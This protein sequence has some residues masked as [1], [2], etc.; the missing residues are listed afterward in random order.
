MILSDD[1]I[2]DAIANSE[3]VIEPF[4][5]TCLGGNSYD[6]HLSDILLTY[7]SKLDKWYN[8]LPIDPREEDPPMTEHTIG[9]DGFVLLPGVLYLG[10]TVEYTETHVHVPNLDGTSSAGRLGISIHATAGRGDVGFRNHWT[11]EISCIQAVKVYAGMPIGQLT[12]NE[13]SG[14]VLNDYSRKAGSAYAGRPRNSKPQPSR[15]WKKLRGK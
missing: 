8:P 10:S 14:E 6:V 2:L 13:V 1:A 7:K 12:Y 9:P 4:D 15:M 11:M 5:R 3:I